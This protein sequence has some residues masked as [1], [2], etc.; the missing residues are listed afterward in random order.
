MMLSII[1]NRKLPCTLAY[2][3]FIL[4]GL[5]CTSKLSTNP[6]SSQQV[7]GE[8]QSLAQ[9][10]EKAPVVSQSPPKITVGVANQESTE[11]VQDVAQPT[12]ITPSGDQRSERS[13]IELETNPDDTLI[14]KFDDSAF[15]YADENILIRGQSPVTNADFVELSNPSQ[16]LRVDDQVQLAQIQTPNNEGAPNDNSVVPLFDPNAAMNTIPFDVYV[17]EGRTGRFMFGV[18]VNS[19]A[20]VTG[21]IVIDERNFDYS[22]VPAN[23]DDFIEG[24]AFRGGGQ[25]FR[26]E[27][28]PGELWER[29]MLNYSNPY[30]RD[31]KVSFNTSAFMYDR[32]YRDW[33]EK[34]AGGRV[35]FG[36]R[37]NPDLSVNLGIRLER[38]KLADP[39]ITGV[40]DLDDALGH[41]NL[42]GLKVGLSHDTRDTP[43]LATEG[44]YL[45]TNFEQI[46]GDYT[47][48]RGSLE[49]RKYYL[50]RER[51]DGTGR[52]VFS[53]RLQYD[54]TGE[55]TPLYD[56]YFA[57]GY[58]TMRGFEFRGASP[59]E[60]GIRVGGHQRFLGT[61]Q[62]LFPFTAD[63]ML[64]GV[65]FTDFGTVERD[66]NID[67]DN[68]R[69]VVGAGLRISMPFMSQAPF[70]LDFGFPIHHAD[71]D[72]KQVFS[73][74]LGFSRG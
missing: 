17:E 72:D 43:F 44:Y 38:V 23:W 64:K 47:Y 49:Y 59:E 50:I 71:T 68:F 53:W 9:L 41:N 6:A 61:L 19:D 70:A 30:F 74:Y 13:G 1:L 60:N 51:A 28:M 29:Y 2:L 16:I 10:A 55:D 25:G 11:S 20:G 40:A 8:R 27:A 22:A 26:L 12:I 45:N 18:G 62:Y 67:P 48:S 33:D 15:H 35:G 32:I 58:T 39:S 54:I 65:V 5:G 69:V 3:S 56:H 52:H 7:I 34:R 57:G 14:P 63:D 66:Y 4:I 37:L 73:F 24:R 21:Q 46:L 31:T 42:V 36:Y